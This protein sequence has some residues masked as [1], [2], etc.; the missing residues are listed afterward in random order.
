M[1]AKKNH[2]CAWL[3]ACANGVNMVMLESNGC[4]A[5]QEHVRFYASLFLERPDNANFL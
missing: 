1:T 3:F 5:V 4:G 2:L